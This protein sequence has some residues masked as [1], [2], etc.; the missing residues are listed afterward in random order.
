MF[1]IT[2]P[3]TWKIKVTSLASSPE[4]STPTLDKTWTIE[5]PKPSDWD[6]FVNS[7]GNIPT[8][9][10]SLT[11]DVQA[12]L[13]DA[14]ISTTVDPIKVLGGIIAIGGIFSYLLLRK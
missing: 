10:T 5:V 7:F 12:A 2:K 8:E 3:G 9:V 6:D 14:G 11:A 13:A 4:C 1:K